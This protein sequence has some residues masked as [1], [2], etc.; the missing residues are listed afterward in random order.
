MWLRVSLLPHH[1][2]GMGAL[3]HSSIPFLVDAHPVKPQ[4][5]ALMLG[6]GQGQEQRGGSRVRVREQGQG[7][8]HS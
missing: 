3:I 2:A 6:P 4:V 5:L 8:Q 1:I 7:R